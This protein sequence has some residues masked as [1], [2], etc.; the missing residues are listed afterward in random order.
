[1]YLFFLTK[2]NKEYFEMTPKYGS[3][4]LDN[5]KLKEIDELRKVMEEN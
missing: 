2:T 5:E 3:M 4:L 1:M